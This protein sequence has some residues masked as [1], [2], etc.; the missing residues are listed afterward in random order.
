MRIKS[1]WGPDII[2]DT[3]YRITPRLGASGSP[4]DQPGTVTDNQTVDNSSVQAGSATSISSKTIKVKRA[5]LK[6]K[7][8]SVYPIT[9]KNAQ[10]TV[11]YIKQSGSSKLKVNKN[12]GKVTVK[13]KTKRGTYKANV[14]VQVSN[15]DNPINKT[16][17]VT[18]K[19]K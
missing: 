1:G 3:I 2:K 18:I 5:K 14:L 9:V 13:K 16:V 11:K 12:S 6:K 4:I 7:A 19:V 17:V 15:N 8:V 10:G